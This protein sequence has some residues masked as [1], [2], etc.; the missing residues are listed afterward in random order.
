MQKNE[1]ILTNHQLLL[2]QSTDY[3][4]TKHAIIIQIT[5]LLNE[6]GKHL[7]YNI[8]KINLSNCPY[9]ITKGENHELLPYVVL[10]YPK[11]N[12][13]EFPI[14]L[15]TMFWWGKYFSF[16]LFI[17]QNIASKKLKNCQLPPNT[18]MLMQN[19]IWQQNISRRYYKPI[20]NSDEIEPV[21]SG[22]IKL[23][24][25]IPIANYE[26]LLELSEIY[27]EWLRVLCP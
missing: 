3:P 7:Q 11:I 23:S 1:I 8:D 6:L 15:R 22:Y 17:H 13:K 16:N 25:T 19:N 9:K 14:L 12:T 2:V 10:D 27:L 20:C 4:I 18:N 5:Q 24:K 21:K 26:N